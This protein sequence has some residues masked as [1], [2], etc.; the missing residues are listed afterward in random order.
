VDGPAQRGSLSKIKDETNYYPHQ[1]EGVR[2]MAYIGSFLLADEMGLGKSLQALTVA[3]IDFELGKAKRVIVV[4]PVSLK[5]NWQDECEKFTNFKAMVLDGTPRERESQIQEFDAYG[6]DILIVNYEQVKAHLKEL[7]ALKFDI[8]IWDEAHYLKN[9]TAQR[10]KASLNL[11]TGR[12]FLLTG[13]PL[14]NQVNELWTILHR[15][16]PHEFPSYQRFV[17]RY[18][19]FGGFKGKQITGPKNKQ[20]LMAR[21]DVVMI[22]RLKRDVLDL[23]EKQYITIKVD[24][25]PEQRRLYKQAK[26]E[27]LITTPSSPT[28]MELE[29]ALTKFLRLKE[30][31]GTTWKF[32]DE[33]HSTKLDRA[34]EMGMEIVDSGEPLVIFTQFMPVI[35]CLLKR[36][37]TLKS[38][39]RKTF[40]LNG[41]VPKETRSDVVKQWGNYRS[42]SGQGAVL[43]AGLQ[44]SGVGLNMTQA[45]KCIFVDKLFVPKLNEQ[46]EDRLHRIGADKTKPIQ[47]YEIICRDTIEQR[48]EAILR[49]KRKLF[50]SLVDAAE[51]KSA[52]YDA[53]RE[54]DAA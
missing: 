53:L 51:W 23:P 36:F 6:Y 13:S 1:I 31:C 26:E 20:E 2:K 16:N 22:R 47:I 48:I 40:F 14:L 25:S 12:S 33:D 37:E 4:C 35:E 45:N 3:A 19:V 52:L 41:S 18:C 24:L 28:P 9:P 42:P 11:I 32:L 5:W 44:V 38:G 49:K 34:V 8:G 54:E 10:T 21:L 39:P 29:N 17:N 27:L 50:D 15:I 7:N 46:A 30:I 43:V